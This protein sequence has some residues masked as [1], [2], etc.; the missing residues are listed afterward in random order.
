VSHGRASGGLTMNR[1]DWLPEQYGIVTSVFE[2]N[3]TAPSDHARKL[4]ELGAGSIRLNF[5]WDIV[6]PSGPGTWNWS[7]FDRW[8]GNA[9]TRRIKMLATI[10]STPAWAN[11]AGANHPPQDMKH[12]YDFVRAV[13]SRYGN[14]DDITFGIWNEPDLQQF[15]DP[16]TPETYAE[17]VRY[18]NAA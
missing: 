16:N 1:L 18:A 10:H 17:L 3:P 7:D 14:K 5:Y 9:R 6:Q 8:V 2:T 15:L 12:W 13:I 11:S 4:D